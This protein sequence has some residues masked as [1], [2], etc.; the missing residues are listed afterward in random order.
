MATGSLR[1]FRKV[2]PL[3]REFPEAVVP[4]MD[5]KWYRLAG[6]DAAVVS[7]PDGT[8]A[9]FYK[10]D[11]A[12]F[13]AQLK[14]SIDLH[15]RLYAEWPQLSALYREQLGQVTSPEAWAG[16]FGIEDDA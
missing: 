9:A 11:P 15:K 5:A 14:R 2:R 10:R 7:M 1:Q 8:S 6:M 13:R 3:S 12:L 4:A 16:T